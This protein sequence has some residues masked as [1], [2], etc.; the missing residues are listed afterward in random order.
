[1]ENGLNLGILPMVAGNG[2]TLPSQRRDLFRRLVDR[3]GQIHRRFALLHRPPG[4]I[5]GRSGLAQP[6]RG[7]FPDAP[8][9]PGHQGVLCLPCLHT[10]LLNDATAS[11]TRANSPALGYLCKGGRDHVASNRQEAVQAVSFSV[12]TMTSA[13]AMTGGGRGWSR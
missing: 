8:A 9:P 2:D 13:V 4:D 10:S 7:P 5:D 6:Q 3:A 1:V 12:A 11:M